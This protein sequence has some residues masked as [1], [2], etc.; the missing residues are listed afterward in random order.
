M[1]STAGGAPRRARAGRTTSHRPRSTSSAPCAACRM[2]RPPRPRPPHERGPPGG[3]CSSARAI[4]ATSSPSTTPGT[5]PS[6]TARCPAV[7]PVTPAA[8]PWI[9]WTLVD[10]AQ[11]HLE[12][13]G[14]DPHDFPHMAL[15]RL[16]L[17]RGGDRA[18]WTP[19]T[20]RGSGYQATADFPS[21][22][23]GVAHAVFLDAFDA[24]VRTF[25]PWTTAITLNDFRSTYAMQATFPALDEVPRSEERRVGTE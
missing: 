10:L 13:V 6:A 3:R 7:F 18:S 12:L 1:L 22:L 16:A 21:H 15:A 24:A 4:A 17:E 2:P 14:L 5:P 19:T 9:D 25:E 11:R 8:R 20:T 23:D